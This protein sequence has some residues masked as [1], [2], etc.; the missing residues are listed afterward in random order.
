F[1]D[2]E[3]IKP[4]QWIPRFIEDVASQVI[5][6]VYRA[7]LE[8]PAH[9]FYA[10]RDHAHYAAHLVLADSRMQ[11]QRGFPLLIDLADHVCKSVFA[12]SLNYLTEAAYAAAGVPFRYVSERAS[13][14]R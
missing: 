11:P 12:G 4:T 8:A 13:R 3:P 9:L 14:H 6:G 10:H 1:W 2:D 7:S 5:V